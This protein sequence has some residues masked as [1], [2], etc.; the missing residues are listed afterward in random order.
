MKQNSPLI[1]AFLCHLTEFRTLALTRTSAKL[2]EIDVRDSSH[3][4]TSYIRGTDR[5]QNHRGRWNIRR[6]PE[7]FAVTNGDPTRRDARP[8]SIDTSNFLSLGRMTERY[9][10]RRNETLVRGLESHGG[11]TVATRRMS[12]SYFNPWPSFAVPPL[13]TPSVVVVVVVGQHRRQPWIFLII[14]WITVKHDTVR[15]LSRVKVR[16]LKSKPVKRRPRSGYLLCALT[17]A[18]GR[19]EPSAA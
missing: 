14:I 15:W 7:R 13:C 4:S 16:P 8:S 12:G 18:Q 5:S 2:N 9:A 11:A 3:S 1:V 6:V 19:T 10:G 17:R